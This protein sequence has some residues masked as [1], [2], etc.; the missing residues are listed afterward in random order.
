MSYQ[1]R[2]ARKSGFLWWKKEKD[3]KILN[4]EIDGKFIS[5]E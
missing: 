3:V 5:E 1:A 4:F 2:I